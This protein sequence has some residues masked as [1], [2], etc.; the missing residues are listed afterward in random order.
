MSCKGIC[1][2]YK[3][4]KPQDSRR[5]V[6]GQKRCQICSMWM[7]WEGVFCPC[8]HNKLRIKPK[9]MQNKETIFSKI[10]ISR[11]ISN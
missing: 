4:T 8:C 7:K 9:K 2:N 10:A 5:Y 6:W 3:A 1:I 11:Q